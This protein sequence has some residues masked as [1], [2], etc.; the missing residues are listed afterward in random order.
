MAWRSITS[1]HFNPQLVSTGKIMPAPWYVHIGRMLMQDGR[2]TKVIVSSGDGWD[3]FRHPGYSAPHQLVDLPMAHAIVPPVGAV[4]EEWR[5]KWGDW[6]DTPTA[7]INNWKEAMSKEQSAELVG[8]VTHLK[9]PLELTRDLRSILGK[10][11]EGLDSIADLLEDLGEPVPRRKPGLATPTADQQ[12]FCL[13]YLIQL[14]L[15]HGRRWREALALAFK[16]ARELKQKR[17]Q[18]ALRDAQQGIRPDLPSP[19]DPNF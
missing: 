4:V 3:S 13:H 2:I 17:E 5:N 16:S 10:T 1:A 19:D 9:Y 12:A 14:Y 15:V 7:F 6:G 18:A 11:S 8:G